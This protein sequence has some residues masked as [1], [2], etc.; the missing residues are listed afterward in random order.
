MHRDLVSDPGGL[1]RALERLASLIPGYSGYKNG[2]SSQAEDRTLREALARHLGLIVG[3]GERALQAASS[4]LG[5]EEEREAKEA[6]EALSR[7]RDRVRFAPAGSRSRL[8]GELTE[9]D[10]QTLLSLDAVLWAAVGELE[11]LAGEWDQ[12]TGN[13]EL[14]WPGNPFLDA[15]SELDEAL[16]ER[17]SFLR[18]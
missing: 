16:E 2:Q 10:R 17:E 8:A 18:R 4:T 11:S 1:A 7:H 5:P 6:L 12:G 14:G 15:L 9:F 13:G 3:R